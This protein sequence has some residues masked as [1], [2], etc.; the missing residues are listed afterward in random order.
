MK[1][2]QQTNI[3]EV[4][5]HERLKYELSSYMEKRI[6]P[7]GSVTTNHV[8]EPYFFIYDSWNIKFLESIPQFRKMADNYKGKRRNVHFRINSP[9]VNLE[10]KYVWYQKLFK[11]HWALSSSFNAKAA[12]LN[13]LSIFINAKYPHLFSLFDLDMEKAE[14]EWWFWLEQQGIPITKTSKTIMFDGYTHKSPAATY[15]R[16]IYSNF[17]VLADSRDE[18]EKDRWDVRILHTKYGLYYSKSLTAHYLD[19]TK[20]EPLKIRESTKKYIKQR[21]MGR[22]DLSFATANA[23]VRTLTKFFAFIF[24]LEPTWND[25]KDLKRPHIEQYIQ[26]LHEDT[27]NKGIIASERYISEELKR[28]NKF[29][30]DVQ[31]YEYGIAPNIDVRLLIFPGDKPK[32]KKKPF[33]QIDYIPDFVLEQLFAHLKDLP[34]DIIPVVWVAFKTGLRIS[35]V[36]ELTT[37]CLVQLN[38]KYSIVTDIEKT[39]VQGHRIPIDEDLAKILSVLISYSKENSTQDNN[40]GGYIFVRYQG[41]RKGKPYT[42]GWIRSH[43]NELAKK[44]HIIDEDGNIFRFKT[45]Q[46]R[47]TYAVK[48]LNGGADIL[49][50]QE[51]LAHASPEMTLRY[52]KLLDETKR[53]AFESVINQGVFSFDL[54]GEVQKINVGEDIPDDILQALWQEHKLNAMDNPYGTCHARLKGDCPHMEAPPCLT[55]NSGSPCKDLA[56][57]FSELDIEK[58]ELHI[59]TTTRAVEV[60]KQH[61]REDMVEKHVQNLNR[62]QGI[63]NN[64]REG[65]IIFGRQNRIKRKYGVKHG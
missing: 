2:K 46:F 27:K 31:K 36:L 48:L 33:G 44:K 61:N 52:A 63:L 3:G 50:V 28:I 39:Q 64:I 43:L 62:Y 54:N 40:P 56:I 37:D 11:E 4:N 65:N 18:W 22:H 1:R 30:G 21:L 14:R 10:I 20:I 59:K 60:A 34:E 32:V 58:Y 29:L 7:D 12:L 51:L 35:D 38:G 45:H 24:S 13:K 42:Q 5:F 41:T 25:L 8:K 47:H 9:T 6:H 15:F 17:L 26:W 19:F 53:K 16:I 49:T 55:C 23:Y 57:G